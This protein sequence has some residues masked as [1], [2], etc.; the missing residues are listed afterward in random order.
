MKMTKLRAWRK[1]SPSLFFF[2]SEL[3]F[4]HYVSGWV[5]NRRD[6]GSAGREFQKAQNF[7]AKNFAR[8]RLGG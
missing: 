3:R 2:N 8:F 6:H 4:A 1:Y 7:F 5:L